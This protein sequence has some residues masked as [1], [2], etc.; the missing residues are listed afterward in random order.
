M[1]QYC[2]IDVHVDADVVWSNVKQFNK[3]MFATCYFDLATFYIDK[4]VAVY[5]YLNFQVNIYNL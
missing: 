1:V 5:S 4:K 2:D 3:E